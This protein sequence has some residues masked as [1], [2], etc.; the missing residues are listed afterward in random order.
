M[1]TYTVTGIN[2]STFNLGEADKLI[3]IFTAERGLIRAVAK[4]AR[5]PGSKMAGRAEPLAV[6]KLQLATGR[7]LDIIAQ[8]ESM[9]TFPALRQDLIR[10]SYALYYA[11][12]TLTF[13]AGLSEETAIYFDELRTAL[14]LLA[15]ATADPAWL[16]LCFELH[17]L[18]LLG[19]RPELTYCVVCRQPLTDAR[20]GA[21]HQD[22]GGIICKVCLTSRDREPATAESTRFSMRAAREIT[23]LVWKHLVLALDCEPTSAAGA[24]SSSPKQSLIAARRIAQSY[25]EH[26]AG[27][28]MKSLDLLAAF[29]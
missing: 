4:G 19:Y 21:F 1:S 27:K 8:A 28:H 24:T 9:E 10:L 12:L 6:N 17:L 2:L 23:P 13:G 7:S 22:W 5:K 29:S 20:L 15:A 18:D 25:I 11:E 26:R 3:T 16:C 14:R